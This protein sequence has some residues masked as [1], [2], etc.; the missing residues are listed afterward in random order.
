MENRYKE[1]SKKIGSALDFS[2]KPSTKLIPLN[3]DFKLVSYR[4][5]IHPAIIPLDY[6]LRIPYY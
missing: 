1:L 4:K 6:S 2:R 3:G 5:T